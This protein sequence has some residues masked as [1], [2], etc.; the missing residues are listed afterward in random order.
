LSTKP[1]EAHTPAKIPVSQDISRDHTLK[2]VKFKSVVENQH[3]LKFSAQNPS[4]KQ[5]AEPEDITYTVK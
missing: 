1:F 4:S 5:A 3:L 2:D